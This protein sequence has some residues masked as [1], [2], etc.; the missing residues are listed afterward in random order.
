MPSKSLSQHNFFE[1]IAHD[2]GAAKRVGVKQSV[3][4]EF[5]AA[6]KGRDLSK[7]PERVQHKAKGGA[8]TRGSFKW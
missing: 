7:L 2:P 1:M 5:V 4:K 3:G 6:D 8:V